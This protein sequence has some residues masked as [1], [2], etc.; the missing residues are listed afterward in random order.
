MT[1]WST[2]KVLWS[3]FFLRV[4][5][6]RAS[7]DHPKFMHDSGIN[8]CITR[9]SLTP[10][11][12]GTHCTMTFFSWR[13]WRWHYHLSSN[14]LLH[15]HAMITDIKFTNYNAVLNFPQQY[16]AI[17]YVNKRGLSFLHTNGQTIHCETLVYCH[18]I[19]LLEWE[20]SKH[21]ATAYDFTSNKNSCISKKNLKK[22]VC[23]SM[24]IPR[25]S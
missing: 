20:V 9:H 7:Q 25:P 14:L 4:Q 3:T 24:L 2:K 22:K 15:H 5:R 12:D 21:R 10:F 18:Y 13:S 8:T 17:S 16:K 1:T 19:T 6:S 11:V 23:Y